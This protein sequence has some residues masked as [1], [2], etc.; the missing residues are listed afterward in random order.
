M[1][2]AVVVLGLLGGLLAVNRGRAAGQ[3]T[4]CQSNL[5][6][7]TGAVQ[8]YADDNGGR[9]PP[10]LATLLDRHYL[11][12]IPTCPSAGTVT[13]AYTVSHA[14]G[15]QSEAF[16]VSCRGENHLGAGYPADHPM[17]TQDGFRDLPEAR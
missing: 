8:M 6:T 2:V 12:G 11:R 5:F 17:R 7:V 4:A 9:Y 10:S 13:Y 3:L 16:T 15:S 14:S 1:G